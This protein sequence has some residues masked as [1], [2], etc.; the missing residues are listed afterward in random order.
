MS[1]QF[2]SG[3]AMLVATLLAGCGVGQAVKDST[4]EAA[5]WAFTT[6]VKTMNIDLTGRPSLNAGSAG[7][8]LSTV[9]RFYQLK[10]S[11]TF[12][13]LSYAQLQANDREL[14]KADLLA[15]RDA[16]LRPEAAVSIIEP[17]H[18]DAQFIGVVG[19]FRDSGTDSAWKLVIPRKQW[20]QTD[21]VKI[22]ASGSTLALIR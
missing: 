20:K 16:V 10:T 8:S 1:W 3:G 18:E 2:Q 15:T 12:L 5:K 6:Q 17:M 21:P 11:E 22:E 9:V 19:F 4:V 7:Q 14:L 13:Q